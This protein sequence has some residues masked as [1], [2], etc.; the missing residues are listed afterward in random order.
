MSN[1]Q[2]KLKTLIYPIKGT[3]YYQRPEQLLPNLTPNQPLH[4]V[5]EKSNKFDALAIQIWAFIDNQSQLLGYIPKNKTLLIHYLTQLKAIQQ[6][7]LP[8]ASEQPLQIKITFQPPL[9]LFIRYHW[10]R[11][12][13][14]ILTS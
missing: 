13:A 7:E 3:F 2:A 6:S 11:F 10:W 1:V 14:T 5:A 12:S 4:L 8:S 9:F